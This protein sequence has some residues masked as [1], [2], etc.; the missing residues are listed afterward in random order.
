I[1]P[2][3]EPA[4]VVTASFDLGLSGYDQTRG[5]Q[6]I[7]D[8]SSRVAA[9]PGVQAVG[10]ANIVAFSD[11]FWISGATIDGYQPQPDE[12]L[13]FD[14]NAVSPDYFRTLGTPLAQGREFTP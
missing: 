2:G 3:L 14:F 6:F 8:L 9:L 5:R 1:D 4:R 12:R 11:L 7:A 10:V 13:T